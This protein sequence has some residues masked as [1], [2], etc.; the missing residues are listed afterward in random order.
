MGKRTFETPRHKPIIT[1]LIGSFKRLAVMLRTKVIRDD[2]SDFFMNIV[3]ETVNYRQ[4]NHI[5]QNDFMDILISLLSNQPD[6]SSLTIDEIAAQAFVFFL[7]GF[8]TSATSMTFVLYELSR[9]LDIQ[10]RARSE[11]MNVLQKNNGELSYETMMEM[12][13]IDQIING[14]WQCRAA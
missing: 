4:A 5:R 3:Q 7:A 11:I 2:V 8:E 9:N 10:R 1:F 6:G 13:Y 12:T 14:E